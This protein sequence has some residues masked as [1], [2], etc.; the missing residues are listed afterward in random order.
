MAI[1]AVLLVHGLSEVMQHNFDAMLLHP[2]SRFIAITFLNFGRGV[3]VFFVISGY[4]LARPFY[5]QYCNNGHKVA[6]GKY[7]L[8]RVTRLEPPYIL[9]LVIYSVARI[10]MLHESVRQIAPHFLADVF[11]LHRYIYFHHHPAIIINLVVWSL[12]LEIQ[13]YIIAPLLGRLYMIPNMYLRRAVII[14]LMLFFM[15]TSAR[16]WVHGYFL[17]TPYMFMQYFLA[18]FLLADILEHPRHTS[19]QH[20]AWDIVS[21]VGWPLIFINATT[22]QTLY[23]L[24]IPIFFVF[25]A[26]FYGKASNGFF[27]QP[28]VA[29]T[30]GMCYSFYLMH[31]LAYSV[32]FRIIRHWTL[33]SAIATVVVQLALLLVF[34]YIVGLIYYVIIERPCMDPQWPQ[35]LWRRVHHLFAANRSHVAP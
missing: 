11:Y 14:G 1:T 6:L 19:R 31:L 21:L 28:F 25:L 15:I 3:E 29:I 32:G 12:E 10:A 20:W 4:I 24:P 13:F 23:F 8:R 35:K 22:I 30:G 5:R 7:Y 27:R 2:V 17:L 26:A 33:P 9:S 18:G 16:G 34:V